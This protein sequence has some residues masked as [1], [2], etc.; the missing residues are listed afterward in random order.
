MAKNNNIFNEFIQNMD[1]VADF[2]ERILNEKL[3]ITMVSVEKDDNYKA[4]D[5]LKIY[6]LLQ[7]ITNCDEKDRK[8]F[9]K[10]LGK[11]L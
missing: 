4:K 1:G 2:D 7:Q 6:D 8:K 10:R 11:V 5:K 3:N 9:V